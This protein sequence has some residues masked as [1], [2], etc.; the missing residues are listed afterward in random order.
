MNISKV[1]QAP[2][3]P[4]TTWYGVLPVPLWNTRAVVVLFSI[5]LIGSISL[6]V[7]RYLCTS[8]SSEKKSPLTNQVQR[9][10]YKG[11]GVD[12]VFAKELF[13][14][15][16]AFLSTEDLVSLSRCSKTLS[17]ICAVDSL[18]KPM[19]EKLLLPPINNPMTYREQVISFYSEFE[20]FSTSNVFKKFRNSISFP[21]HSKLNMPAFLQVSIDSLR[22]CS[23][24]KRQEIISQ[25][26]EMNCRDIAFYFCQKE[27][28]PI[29][30]FYATL[31]M[32]KTCQIDGPPKNQ[33]LRLNFDFLWI[34][35]IYLP[36]LLP[37]D[38]YRGLVVCV[39]LIM[40]RLDIV[41]VQLKKGPISPKRCE[42]AF[43]TAVKSGKIDIVDL[44]LKNSEISTFCRGDAVWWAVVGG[45]LDI[46][47][48]LLKNGEIS[49]KCRGDAV[50]WAVVGG[51]LDII[52]LLLKNGEITEENILYVFKVA[53]EKGHRCIIDLLMR[54][55]LRSEQDLQ[56]AVIKA[57][58]A[59]QMKDSD[60]LEICW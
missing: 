13:V 30:L 31:Q 9:L 54:Y 45:R 50:W 5:G 39:A 29:T 46:I 35:N 8:H 23:L 24:A 44:L 59:Q 19:S 27:V 48:L 51:R 37:A 42:D 21:S 55:T 32:P 12:T 60:I 40:N 34:H 4:V 53:D 14:Y 20:K 1:G 36:P 15:I 57:K 10:E 28:I 7:Y 56:D 41:K 52:D 58:E 17:S 22:T 43:M 26:M 25:A 6:W 49:I 33:N 47:D 2:F 38:E 18:W 3:V 11:P 16:A